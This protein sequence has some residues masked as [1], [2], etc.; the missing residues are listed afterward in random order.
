[1]SPA[2]TYLL[3]INLNKIYWYAQFLIIFILTIFL[4]STVHQIIFST[5]IPAVLYEN[6]KHCNVCEFRMTA[7][8]NNYRNKEC[9][10]LLHWTSRDRMGV[11]S[12]GGY[13]KT[14]TGLSHPFLGQTKG[15]I[16][17]GNNRHSLEIGKNRT[18]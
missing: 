1:M 11:Y 2:F 13:I 9:G 18:S 17:W 14:L 8:L 12:Y 10:T 4:L 5:N 7:A 15:P 6:N 3:H 16:I